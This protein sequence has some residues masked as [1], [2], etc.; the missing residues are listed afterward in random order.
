MFNLFCSLIFSNFFSSSYIYLTMEV[1]LDKALDE[2]GML[3]VPIR[4]GLLSDLA[5]RQL[6]PAKQCATNC[7]S[8][9]ST[10]YQ[11][12]HINSNFVS[13]ITSPALP[14]IR[15]SRSAS[16]YTEMHSSTDLPFTRVQHSSDNDNDDDD[17]TKSRS[18]S[19]PSPR[20][21]G[22]GH[23]VE[24]LGPIRASR[25]STRQR[26]YGRFLKP[27]E[28]PWLTSLSHR[29]KP[30]CSKSYL[31]VPSCDNSSPPGLVNG[32]FSQFELPNMDGLS[33]HDDPSDKFHR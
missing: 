22:H 13:S 11:I 10:P 16:D 33:L 2:L 25:A 30:F 24:D 5:F 17:A 3:A 23:S 14:Q 7:P 28:F 12:V 15:T 21:F 19:L 18:G 4:V 32:T 20:N 26:K 8:S 6:P 9:A 1:D 31:N 29:R 27:Y